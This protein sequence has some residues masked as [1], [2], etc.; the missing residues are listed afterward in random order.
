MG[1]FA[2]MRRRRCPGTSVSAPL[3]AALYA[4]AGTTAH[5]KDAS[6]SYEHAASLFA[7]AGGNSANGCNPAYLCVAGNGYNGP[8]GLGVP[9]GLAALRSN[10]RPP[11]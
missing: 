9:F 3:V 1:G 11:C 7:I 10:R 4:L 2:R 5:M 8:A 6:G